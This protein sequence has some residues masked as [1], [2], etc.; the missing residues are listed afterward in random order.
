MPEGHTIHRLARDHAR[1]L[2]GQVLHV[3]SPQGRR[4][5]VAAVLD[6]HPLEAVAAYGKHLFYDW[7]DAPSLHVHLGLF[8]SFREFPSPPP[9][10]RPSV[11]LRLEGPRATVDLVGATVCELVDPARRAQIV[12]RLGP[13]LLVDA[14][15]SD[16]A[17]RVW[18]H[19]SRSPVPIGVA[20][21]DQRVL[22]GVGNVYRAEALFVNGIHPERPAN[23]LSRAEFDAV[24]DTLRRMLRQGVE[25]R[26]IVTVHPAERAAAGPDGAVAP[27]DAFY[28][29]MQQCCRRCGGPIRAWRLGTR[30][31]YACERCQPLPSEWPLEPAGMDATSAPG[32]ASAQPVGAP[33]VTSAG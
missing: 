9:P 21:L 5:S 15:A 18:Q 17:E 27:A 6:Q 26:R 22:S 20:L 25:D 33:G 10:P 11:Q 14:R 24:W 19:L 12:G 4:A 16:D 8:G 32:A 23:S 30:T 28:V 1:A 13:D 3:T 7:R 31:A 2:A 29:Y